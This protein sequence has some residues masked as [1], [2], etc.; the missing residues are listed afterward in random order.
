MA[1]PTLIN[2]DCSALPFS[3]AKSLALRTSRLTPEPLTAP[4][5]DQEFQLRGYVGTAILQPVELPLYDPRGVRS[6]T[7]KYEY[8]KEAIDG[9]GGVSGWMFSRKAN[10]IIPF[11]SF[12]EQRIHTSLELNPLVVEI[13]A[14][15]PEFDQ[16]KW[17]LAK[18]RAELMH[19]TIP[20]FHG[21]VP[22]QLVITVDCVATLALPGK[23]ELLYHTISGKP[24]AL[25]QLP[26]VIRRHEKEK[27]LRARWN[28]TF[29]I[30]TDMTFSE[31]E[32]RNNVRILRW[33]SRIRDVHAHTHTAA[34]FAA[35]LKRTKAKDCVNQVLA[36][37]GNRMNLT[38]SECYLYFA[39]AH[40][41]GYLRWDH[42]FP[43]R[44]NKE[45][46]LAVP[47]YCY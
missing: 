32:H 28:S 11:H 26:K 36:T 16:E 33:L 8:W 44:P 5:S 14:Q 3:R 23:Q 47:P 34:E 18:Q 30:M 42:K 46:R 35:K 43:L 25:L 2:G 10:G 1:R 39:V 21:K 4:I 20:D 27:V 41:C 19:R 37:I 12:I 45:F 6:V 17:A 13:R 24:A 9:R 40:Y 15:Y 29:E 38:R 31:Q 7:N 22:A